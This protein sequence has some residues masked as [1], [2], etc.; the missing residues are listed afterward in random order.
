MA[1]FFVSD[2]TT[3]SVTTIT[4]SWSECYCFFIAGMVLTLYT[5]VIT[6]KLRLLIYK[7]NEIIQITSTNYTGGQPFQ[8]QN[9]PPTKLITAS[10]IKVIYEMVYRKYFIV[11]PANRCF[12]SY[13]VFIP[14]SGIGN[15]PA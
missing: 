13:R 2:A 10:P 8:Y 9:N 6:S 1:H 4:N 7:L 14:N 15:I 11:L 5:C 12:P 3:L